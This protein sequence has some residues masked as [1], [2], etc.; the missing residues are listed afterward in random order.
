MPTQESTQ[1]KSTSNAEG[2]S[3]F[4]DVDNQSMASFNSNIF[5]KFKGLDSISQIGNE[6]DDAG[7]DLGSIKYELKARE[8]KIRELH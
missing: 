8:T 2:S 4:E 5:D 3:F 1:E 6:D 7:F